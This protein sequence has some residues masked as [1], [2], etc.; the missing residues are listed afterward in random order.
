MACSTVILEGSERPAG[1][2]GAGQATSQEPNS[3]LWGP[4]SCIKLWMLKDE[5]SAL[6]GW[7][8]ARRLC[9]M[10]GLRAR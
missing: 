6:S 7:Q 8:A 5:R 9:A 1:E 2:F 3:S 4:K 10:I